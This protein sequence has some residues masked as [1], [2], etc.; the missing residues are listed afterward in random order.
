MI[1]TKWQ[2]LQDQRSSQRKIPSDRVD[3]DSGGE[4]GHGAQTGRDTET[5]C[6]C[7]PHRTDDVYAP[8]KLLHYGLNDCKNKGK[9][10]MTERKISFL[11][12]GPNRGHSPVEWEDFPSFGAAATK[13]PMIYMPHRG[14][15]SLCFYVSMFLCFFISTSPSWLAFQTIIGLQT[16]WPHRSSS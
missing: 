11:G 14:D 9:A 10:L 7:S 1:Y 4:L 15:F 3:R 13:E 5:K 16:D 2:E 8:Q 12:S 6:P